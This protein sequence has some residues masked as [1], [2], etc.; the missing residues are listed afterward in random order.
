MDEA[1]CVRL[2]KTLE[3]TSMLR[4]QL[5]FLVFVQVFA[6]LA[7]A[8]RPTPLNVK[9]GLWETTVSHSIEGMANMPKM[10]KLPKEALAKMPPEQRAR[11]ETM[12]GQE[13]P[14]TIR[15]CITKDK[16]EKHKAFDSKNEN[17]D[18]KVVKSTSTKF[19]VRFQCAKESGAA[20]GTLVVEAVNPE[21]VKGS[22]KTNGE[23]K[24]KNVDVEVNFT[25]K[26][27]GPDCGALK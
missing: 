26:Y 19:E 7:F 20:T 8:E 3:A 27:V 21:L 11:M 17:C 15:Q 14:G 13:N 24:G 23:R 10:P 2:F 16:L 18:H 5:L 6:C 9:M 1:P 22:M 4:N 12:F 25:S